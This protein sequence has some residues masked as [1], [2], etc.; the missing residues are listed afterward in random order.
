MVH[1]ADHEEVAVVRG[2]EAHLKW[3]K[4]TAVVLVHCSGISTLSIGEGWSGVER[5]EGGWRPG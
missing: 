4:Y 1:V 5:G 2:E 3:Y